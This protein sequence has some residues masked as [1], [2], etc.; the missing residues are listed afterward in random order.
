MF[1]WCDF[2][3]IPNN[4]QVVKN[5]QSQSYRVPFFFIQFLGKIGQNNRFVPPY[6]G[7]AQAFLETLHPPLIPSIPFSCGNCTME[8]LRD[9]CDQWPVGT[10]QHETGKCPCGTKRD[11]CNECTEPG[12]EQRRLNNESKLPQRFHKRR[13]YTSRK[14]RS[15]GSV[16]SIRWIS[17]KKT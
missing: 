17:H 10:V 12:S 7:L 4:P 1:T 13:G 16:N 5:L 3:K 15:L 6:L 11:N 14:L 2:D 9:K 8:Y